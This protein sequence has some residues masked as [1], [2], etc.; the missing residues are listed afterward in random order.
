MR[1]EGGG[2]S[3]ACGRPPRL[4]I[5]RPPASF[6]AVQSH[7]NKLAVSQFLLSATYDA[8]QRNRDAA[9][10]AEASRILAMSWE[11][12]HTRAAASTGGDGRGGRDAFDGD[13]SA[14]VVAVSHGVA[15]TSNG[16]VYR[17]DDEAADDTDDDEVGGPGGGKARQ[18]AARQKRKQQ[19]RRE[20]RQHGAASAS[21]GA[22]SDGSAGGAS[23]VAASTAPSRTTMDITTIASED[24]D[25]RSARDRDAGGAPAAVVARRPPS[26]TLLTSASSA[27]AATSKAL[28]RQ[29][30]DDARI[31]EQRRR[32]QADRDVAERASA[33]AAV[34]SSSAPRARSGSSS[35]RAASRNSSSGRGL[36][37]PALRATTPP[38]LL[39]GARVAKATPLRS[40]ALQQSPLRTP[41][42]TGGKVRGDG[43]N[44]GR[45][46]ATPRASGLAPSDQ[47]LPLPNS[48]KRD[49]VAEGCEALRETTGALKSGVTP[50]ALPLRRGSVPL[51]PQVAWARAAEAAQADGSRVTAA[52]PSPGTRVG[53]AVW[54]V[55]G[56]TLARVSW[57][58]GGAA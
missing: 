58:G 8:L 28:A 37:A 10:A 9:E 23:S 52:L 38:P 55:G 21:P 29:H 49:G 14:S 11:D 4:L 50:L 26:A 57:R 34:R 1:R 36:A 22:R 13:A 27:A 19:S 44:A 3:A 18:R 12:H 56:G 48:R 24:D 35:A 51:P 45:Y 16:R 40:A 5:H 2:G 41:S 39:P 54:D 7:E 6:V 31:E 25:E 42:E 20:L 17:K 47:R 32:E 43:Y 33:A 46:V 15:G 30:L 53:N